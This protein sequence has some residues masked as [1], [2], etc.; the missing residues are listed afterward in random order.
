MVW[1][2]SLP[3]VG[4]GFRG[5]SPRSWSAHER[6][7]RTQDDHELLAAHV[8]GDPDAFGELFARHR[9]RLWA[10][11]LR[12]MGNPEDAADALQ[13]GLI[14][15]YRRAGRFRGDAAVTT[16]LHRVVVNACLDR[17]R[18][19]KVRAADPLPD[20]LEEYAGRGSA[21]TAESEDGPDEAA[22][23]ATATAGA[24]A[25]GHPA[26][27]AA[28]RAGA[29]RHGGLPGR[30]G[31]RDPRLRGRHGEVRCARGRAR[32]APLLG[33]LRGDDDV[34]PD[35]SGNPPDTRGRPIHGPPRAGLRTDRHPPTPTPDTLRG[36]E[37]PSPTRRPDPD[38]PT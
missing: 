35:T 2:T 10:V 14:S 38:L 4:G 23:A 8:A 21:G 5:R 27:R 32:L 36:G 26:R 3:N 6:R 31:R 9:D 29:G 13:D 19:R 18:P 12:T 11:A 30:R 20:D 16:W 15:A 34:T 28:G 22:S 1:L 33:V 7:T 37:P 17:M 24:H 25:A